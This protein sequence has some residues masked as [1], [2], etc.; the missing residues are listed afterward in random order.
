M[1]DPMFD[2]PEGQLPVDRDAEQ[3]LIS[4]VLYAPEVFDSLSVKVLPEYFS[5]R[6]Y[7]VVW[8]T[9]LML[10]QKGTAIDSVAVAGYLMVEKKLGLVGGL[11][12]LNAMDNG[13]GTI[14]GEEGYINRVRDKWQKRE[15]L[16]VAHKMRSETRKGGSAAEIALSN[17]ELLRSI[18]EQTETRTPDLSL[19]QVIHN[20]G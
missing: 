8:E 15:I 4:R 14:F 13:L 5:H 9:C 12:G 10:A 17:Q 18:A 1:F 20:A 7:R 6:P 3:A 2:V 16:G 19:G 11:A